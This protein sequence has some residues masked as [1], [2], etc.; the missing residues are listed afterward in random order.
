[1]VWLSLMKMEQLVPEDATVS[2]R[3]AE[4]LMNMKNYDEA[5]KRLQNVLQKQP[6]N[7]DAQCLMGEYLLAKGDETSAHQYF[8]K[9]IKAKPENISHRF[10]AA[11]RL[12]DLGNYEAAE[13]QMRHY[14]AARCFV[15]AVFKHFVH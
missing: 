3:C 1:M 9:A 2:M 15:M 5:S 13:V 12:Y 4:L 8:E 14:L 7:P 6:E 11:K 10:S